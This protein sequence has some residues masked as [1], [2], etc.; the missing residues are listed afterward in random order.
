[1]KEE[2]GVPRVSSVLLGRVCVVRLDRFVSKFGGGG[3]VGKLKTCCQESE[4]GTTDLKVTF[5]AGIEVK[6]GVH[7]IESDN[8][9][10]DD[11]DT[12]DHR[13]LEQDVHS[14]LGSRQPRFERCET[15]V[16]DEDQH[17]GQHDPQVACDEAIS[18]LNRGHG[19]SGRLFCLWL[20]C[21]LGCGN[22]CRL[23]CLG[24]ILCKNWG[25]IEI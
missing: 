17:S 20:G 12:H 18:L 24:R 5:I 9:I 19:R 11:S 3:R 22:V 4:A 14:V 25:G 21:F 8:S 23:S 2:V 15:K 10:G 7:Q 16:H 1:M 6:A 13:V